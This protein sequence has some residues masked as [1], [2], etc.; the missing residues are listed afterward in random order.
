M[1]YVTN[2]ASLLWSNRRDGESEETAQPLPLSSSVVV[3][4]TD[5]PKRP[6]Y[7]KA[8]VTVQRASCGTHCANLDCQFDTPG[9][10]EPQLS[11]FLHPLA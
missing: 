8:C 2:A 1:R 7:P 11:N 6:G 9:K 5:V 4:C 3:E 10:E